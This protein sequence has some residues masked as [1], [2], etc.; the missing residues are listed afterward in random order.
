MRVGFYRAKKILFP[1]PTKPTVVPT[2]V[3][4]TPA[5]EV[6][7]EETQI[8]KPLERLETTLADIKAVVAENKNLRQKLTAHE[9]ALKK[10]HR[11]I[12]H[13]KKAEKELDEFKKLL[14]SLQK[15]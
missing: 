9:K 5:V 8:D 4:P 7:Q 6:Q 11:E 12:K 10:A 2:P 13:L 14:A 3:V 1:K 15:K